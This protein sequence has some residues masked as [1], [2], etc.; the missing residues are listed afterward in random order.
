MKIREKSLI[1]RTKGQIAW[2]ELQ[3]QKYKEKGLTDRI[4][5]VKKKQRALLMHMAAERSNILRWALSV[6][7]TLLL[8]ILCQSPWQRALVLFEFQR[9]QFLLP[10]WASYSNRPS[11]SAP[12]RNLN[13]KTFRQQKWMLN[14]RVSVM[15]W[16]T[17]HNGRP[18]VRT[19]SM[20]RK[21]SKSKF[22]SVKYFYLHSLIVPSND[23]QD[24]S[25][26]WGRTTET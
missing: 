7:V 8:T 23:F 17:L 24:P 1:D 11:H 16:I 18:S 19:R 12:H 22:T 26:T 5:A 2:L 15:N 10:D 25:E 3:K 4:S 9:N 21:D 6:D 13:F 14:G 20:E